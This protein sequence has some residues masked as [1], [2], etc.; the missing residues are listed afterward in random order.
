MSATSHQSVEPLTGAFPWIGGKRVLAKTILPRI[1]AVPHVCFAEPF[2][3][4]GGIF[5]RRRHRSRSEA[6]NDRSNDIAGFFRVLQRHPDALLEELSARLTS[7]AEHERLRASD[8]TGMTDIERAARFYYLQYCAYGGKPE[9]VWA[10]SAL[11]RARFNITR[12]RPML[13]RIHERLA[14]VYIDCL[15]FE[16][17][18]RRWDRPTTL[19][20]I[21]PPYWGCER[22]YGKNLFAR[23]DFER[24]AGVLR[25]IQGRFIMSLNDRSE[26][27]E[28]FAGFQ[29]ETVETVY[30]VAGPAQPVTELLISDGRG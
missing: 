8:P 21:D 29:V 13:R 27:R 12:L 3:G 14:A 15:D 18:I 16:A 6:I 10:G 23:E 17:F 2:V 9:A 26:V 24:L 30:R 5:L 22:Y 20:Y 1:D 28:I 25:G 4:A 7:R 11:S 19:F